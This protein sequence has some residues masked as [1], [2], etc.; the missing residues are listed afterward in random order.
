M[1]RSQK[2]EQPLRSL[3]NAFPLGSYVTIILNHVRGISTLSIQVKALK[4]TSLLY[5][6]QRIST[7]SVVI[8]SRGWE[9][10]LLTHISNLLCMLYMWD[11]FTNLLQFKIYVFL[12]QTKLKTSLLL[13]Y[14]YTILPEA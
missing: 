1:N 8:L 4:I 2:G 10:N 11:S 7:G 14:S 13:C 5:K 12:T 6:W 9:C 3:S